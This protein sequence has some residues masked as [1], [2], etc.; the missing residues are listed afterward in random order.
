[1]TP[2]T[3]VDRYQLLSGI[4]CLLP[5]A[6]KMKSGTKVHEVMSQKRAIFKVSSRENFKS[7]VDL[8]NLSRECCKLLVNVRDTI[9]NTLFV[10]VT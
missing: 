8:S 6:A 3:F 7:H 9:E 10:S 5:F 4:C 2:C 1:V